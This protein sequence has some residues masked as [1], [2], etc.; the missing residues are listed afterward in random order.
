VD[1][2]A[3]WRHGRRGGRG[4]DHRRR[5]AVQG[6]QRE[7]T[8]LSAIWAIGMAV[9]ISFITATPGYSEDLMSYLFG[10]ILMV[11]ATDLW[12]HGSRWTRSSSR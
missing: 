7:D 4:A 6:R 8:V 11:G 5:H 1:D 9:G 3:L 2:A 10:N 12:A